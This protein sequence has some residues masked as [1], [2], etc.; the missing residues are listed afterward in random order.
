M[1][2]SRGQIL[3]RKYGFLVRVFVGRNPVTGKRIYENE[4]VRS[5]KKK[6][7]EKVLTAILRKLDSGELLLE[8]STQTV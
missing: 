2:S 1:A 4:Q 7:A 8:P 6:D 3:P 5:S